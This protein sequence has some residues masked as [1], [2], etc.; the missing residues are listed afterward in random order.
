MTFRTKPVAIISALVFLLAVLPFT[1][2]PATAQSA[3]AKPVLTVQVDGTTA[4]LS[5]EPVQGAARYEIWR[6]QEDVGW[7][8]LDDDS[9]TDT[10]YTD[11]GLAAGI[12]YFWTG[13][14]VD[15]DGDKSGWA[16]YV[17][18]TIVTGTSP[19]PTNTPIPTQDSGSGPTPYPTYTPYPTATPVFMSSSQSWRHLF[20]GNAF[21]GYRLKAWN[22]QGGGYG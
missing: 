7:T 4:E 5:W 16:D 20:S 11:A 13:R 1:T 17:E 22:I 3:L 18:A 19:N 15:S 12:R 8:Q 6:W 2:N 21:S 14:T 9:L 10:S